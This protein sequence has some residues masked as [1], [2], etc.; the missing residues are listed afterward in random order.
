MSDIAVDN[1]RVSGAA[2]LFR[3]WTVAALAVLLA[4]GGHQAAHSIM[5]GSTEAIPVELLAF[6]AAV[7]APIAVG[8]AGKRL[9]NWSTAL[10]AVFGQLAFHILYS[11][12]YSG[13]NIA[14]SGHAHHG[15]HQQT[16][17]VAAEAHTTHAAAHTVA[18][19]AVM[20][21]AHLIAA[22]LTIA[23]IVH[24]E[25]SLMAVIAWLTL[26]PSRFVLAALPVSI[27]RPKTVQPM[28]RVWIPRPMNVSQTRSTR[29]PPVLA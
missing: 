11:L 1:S 13:A 28:I 22:V 19:D 15:H 6:S 14:H 24:G 4:A 3:G 10:T 26:A 20:L 16:L 12:P 27:A 9:S 18:E 21:A 17:P 29:G 25:R 7:T 5:H 8:L 23:A 2:R